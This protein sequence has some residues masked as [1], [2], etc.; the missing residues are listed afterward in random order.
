MTSTELA[1]VNVLVAVAYAE[2]DDHAA[3]LTWLRHVRRF[4]TTPVTEMALVRLLM[5]RNVVPGGVTIAEALASLRSI[6][7]LTTAQF[8]PD[9]TSLADQRAITAHVV[10]TKQVTDTHL[11]NLAISNGGVLATFDERLHDCLPQKDRR[12][13]RVLNLR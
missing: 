3:A 1:D 8:W 5:N 12:H 4:A 2:H 9:A 13:V 11:L 7:N 10:G 6:K